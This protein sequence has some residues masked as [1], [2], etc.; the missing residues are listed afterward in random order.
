MLRIGRSG[1]HS[2]TATVSLSR[3]LEPVVLER[4]ER[5]RGKKNLVNLANGN[6]L[7]ELDEA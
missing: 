7:K 3:D 5:R 4:G 6:C 1:S 2:I